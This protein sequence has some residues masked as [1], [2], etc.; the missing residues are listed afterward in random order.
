[1]G[2]PIAMRTFRQGGR[3]RTVLRKVEPQRPRQMQVQASHQQREGEKKG[4]GRESV[5]PVIDARSKYL[6]LSAKV[7][8]F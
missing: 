2:D 7:S 5:V 4:K 6:K 8:L 1:M 3:L